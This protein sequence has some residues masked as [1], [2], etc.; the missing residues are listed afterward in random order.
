MYPV[1]SFL[2]F[3]LMTAR[4][5]RMTD[6]G[7]FP[8]RSGLHAD[9]TLERDSLMLRLMTAALVAFSLPAFAT[10]AG[11]VKLEKKAD[12]IAV[13]IDGK[14]FTNYHTAKTQMKPYFW[15]VLAADGANI[16][17]SLEKPEDH[18]HHKGIWCA[19]DEVNEVKFWAEKGRIE[20]VS[21]EIVK[22]EGNPAQLRVANHWLG[23]NGQPLLKETVTVSIHANRRIDYDLEFTAGAS[24]VTFADTKEGMFG[25]RL[26][27]P[28]RGK[29]GGKIANA[30]EMKG[31]EGCWGK[32]SKWVDYVGQLGGKT[33]GVAIFDD[34]KNFRKSRFHV[35]NY[36]LFTL[37]PFG[38]KSYTNGVLPADPLTLE[39][40]KSVRL[41][42]GLYIH[43]GD[44]AQGR[45]TDVYDAFV[46]GN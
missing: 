13:T 42:Y 6:F 44:A 18:P 27:N 28:L 26:A 29:E 32:E 40:G 35:R 39:P 21:I 3:L 16:T 5:E 33:Y 2:V 25:I 38:Q 41:R 7:R 23:T 45:V 30:E 10:A 17:R 36:G 14:E 46:K 31:E 24:P 11:T 34:P 12:A 43:D 8:I 15:P 9:L 19:I 37:S 20:N 1:L 22:A 4:K